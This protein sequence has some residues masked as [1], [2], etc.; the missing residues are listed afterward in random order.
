MSIRTFGHY[1]A[2]LLFVTL[3]SGCSVPGAGESG[4]NDDCVAEPSKC[5][6]EAGEREY[7]E[8]EAARLNRESARKLRRRGGGWF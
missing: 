5:R 4:R 2:A 8:E 3:L 1:G 6:Y 7:A